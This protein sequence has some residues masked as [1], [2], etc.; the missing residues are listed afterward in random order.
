M[1]PVSERSLRDVIADLGFRRPPGR[2]R[3]LFDAAQVAAIKD[4]LKCR[5][6]LLPE[7]G[8]GTGTLSSI[9]ASTGESTRAARAR[10]TRLAAQQV[11]MRQDAA[12]GK[13]FSG[14]ATRG[15]WNLRKPYSG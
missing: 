3:Y 1:V 14:P 13:V 5:S 10:L 9:A 2:K 12:S 11:R 8:T 4:A 6:T 15:K 7:H